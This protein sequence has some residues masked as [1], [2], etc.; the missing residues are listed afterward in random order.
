VHGI[1]VRM[2]QTEDLIDQALDT[3]GTFYRVTLPI[4]EGFGFSGIYESE[5]RLTASAETRTPTPLSRL[6]SHGRHPEMPAFTDR[7]SI[8]PWTCTWTVCTSEP[9][10]GTASMATG[11]RGYASP[12]TSGC[13]W[14]FRVAG[15]PR[16]RPSR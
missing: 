13:A 2:W 15:K 12:P 14:P 7:H 4:E 8:P 10:G 6:Q 3:W 11:P 5:G 9:R 16:L 1:L